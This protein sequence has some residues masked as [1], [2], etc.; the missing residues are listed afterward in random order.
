MRGA[1]GCLGLGHK[2]ALLVLWLWGPFCPLVVGLFGAW[3][4]GVD[5]TAA[6]A[7]FFTLFFPIKSPPLSTDRET[8]M[9]MIS[10]PVVTIQH[11][12]SLVLSSG[13]Y[14]LPGFAFQLIIYHRLVAYL[15]D[16]R[17]TD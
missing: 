13:F 6:V 16:L 9:H 17:T 8:G 4:L 3:L 7:P 1:P 5:M 10:L 2:V 11:N 12:S 15:N 14:I